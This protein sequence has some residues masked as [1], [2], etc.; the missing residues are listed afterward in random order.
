M[1]TIEIKIKFSRRSRQLSRRQTRHCNLSMHVKTHVQRI[2]D[3]FIR[4]RSL[5]R[6]QSHQNKLNLR[7]RR[8]QERDE[9][10]K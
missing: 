1:S 3:D 10:I 4:R 8:E 7:E 6:Q 2:S 9:V 5:P